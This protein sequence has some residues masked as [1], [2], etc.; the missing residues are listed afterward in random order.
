MAEAAIDSVTPTVELA[1]ADGKKVKVNQF[2]AI[3]KTIQARPKMQVFGEVGKEQNAAA[4]SEKE[5]KT[6]ALAEQHW[7]ESKDLQLA[8]PEK[9]DY[10]DGQLA[11]EGFKVKEKKDD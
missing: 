7:T 4:H 2:D 11:A 9:Q 5:K 1:E 10:I 3:L 6:V 8:F